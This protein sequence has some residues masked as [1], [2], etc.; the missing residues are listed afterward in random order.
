MPHGGKREG[1][2]RKKGVP[3]KMTLEFRQLSRDML[4]ERFAKV[5]G[6]IDTVAETDPARACELTLRLAEF[7]LPKLQRLNIDLKEIPIE[8]I[9]TELE[10][11]EAL[12]AQGQ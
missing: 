10:R 7:F 2:G 8:E 12:A 4:E 3:N 11:R 5:G 9:A 1:A 6:W